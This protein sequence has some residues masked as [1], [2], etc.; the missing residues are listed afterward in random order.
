MTTSHP[1]AVTD[2]GEPATHAP[3]SRIA[4]GTVQFGK[5]YGVANRLGQL[6]AS[7]AAR[8]LQLGRLNGV[9]CLDTAIAYGDSERV[10]GELGVSEWNVVTKLPRIPPETR[11]I[12]SWVRAQFAGSLQRLRLRRCYGLLLHN[13]ADLAGPTGT[14]IHEAV[15]ALKSDGF[16]RKVGV[17][18]YSPAE[19]D[20]TAARYPLD[21]VQAPLNVVDRRFLDSGWLRR[22]HDAGTEVHVRSSFL[23]GL[24]LLDADSIPAKFHPW[25]P[26]WDEWHRW[27]RASE[28]TALAG[29]LGFP[30][31]IPEVGKVV[32]GVD[33]PEQFSQIMNAIGAADHR[34]PA[35]LASTDENLINPSLWD[36]L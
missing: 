3:G 23:Q 26:L 20:A 18:V 11:D 2:A 10:L 22:L 36:R 12:G 27:L 29:C 34:P 30:L 35:H 8:V 25:K 32:V 31:S 19:L 17:S 33:S 9:D 24:L 21:L 14:A 1:Q 5:R 4:I 16:V 13:A 6:T 28:I 15:L 7:D